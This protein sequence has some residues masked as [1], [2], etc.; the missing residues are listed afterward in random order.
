M[1]LEPWTWWTSV[2][3]FIEKVQ[4]IKKLNSISR[5]RLNFRRRPFLCTT[6][7]RNLM[8]T[9]NF[10]GTFDQLFLRIILWNFHRRCLSIC[11]IPWCKTSR[12]T[13]NSNQ[14]GGSCLKIPLLQTFLQVG[15]DPIPQKCQLSNSGVSRRNGTGKHWSLHALHQVAR[16]FSDSTLK[17]AVFLQYSS[18]FLNDCSSYEKNIGCQRIYLLR[19]W[20]PKLLNFAAVFLC[21]NWN[22][23]SSPPSD[24]SKKKK[25]KKKDCAKKSRQK[26]ARKC[27]CGQRFGHRNR[28]YGHRSGDWKNIS[29]S[30]LQTWNFLWRGLVV[31]Q[32]IKMKKGGQLKLP[33][34]PMTDAD[35]VQQNMWQKIGAIARH[36]W[37]KWCPYPRV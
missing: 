20:R 19:N 7:Y 18:P 25:R 10:G 14:G 34:R 29:G 33:C 12:M 22:C 3:N 28:N 32:R 6:L 24:C 30:P 21:V 2:P 23:K 9:G 27:C 16:P 15:H 11:A 31:R 5:A 36:W 35:S 37:K 26:T 17:K 8:Q 13:K 4:A 1:A